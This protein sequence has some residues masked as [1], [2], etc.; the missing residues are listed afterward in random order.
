MV[1][2]VASDCPEQSARLANMSEIEGRGQRARV[3]QFSLRWLLPAVNPTFCAF[4]RAFEARMVDNDVQ[5]IIG[6]CLP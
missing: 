5:I 2:S 1:T 6:R 3:I 4:G